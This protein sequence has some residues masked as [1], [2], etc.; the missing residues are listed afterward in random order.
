M[1]ANADQSKLT[2]Y[3]PPSA[4]HIL[5]CAC[6]DGTRGKVLKE[7]GAKFVAGV[8]T[9]A[10]LAKTAAQSLDQV[11]H[12]TLEDTPLSF[13]NDAFDCILCDNVLATVHDAA[14]PLELLGTLLAPGGILI[15]TVPN[16]Q[17]HKTVQMLLEGRWDYTGEGIMS[18]H[19]LRYFTAY[20][21]LNLL[22]ST[23]Y[24]PQKCG[25]LVQDAASS[26]PLDK[27]QCITLGN[28]TIGPLTKD[29]HLAYLTQQYI[30]FA[31][32]T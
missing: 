25:V 20:E 28:A 7:R 12:G 26:L 24:Q 13:D 6:G 10:E 16:I 30:L 11:V 27:D 1:P 3:V 21:I 32:R 18:H 22:R 8:E 29:E 15:V 4:Q 31:T 5:D 14:P 19:H 2:Q 23:G 17:Y 9:N